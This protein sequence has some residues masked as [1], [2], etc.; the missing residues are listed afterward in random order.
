[1]IIMGVSGTGKS[2][3]AQ[4][5]AKQIDGSYLDADDFHTEAAKLI[6]SEGKSI[7]DT[8]RQAWV[9]DICQYLK[10]QHDN[11]VI[12]LAFSGLRQAHRQQLQSI[13]PEQCSIIYLHGSYDVIATRMSKRNNH[14]VDAGFLDSQFAQ[15]EVPKDD[16]NINWLD[17]DKPLVDL[18]QQALELV[19]SYYE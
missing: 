11:N 19:K 17:I 7:S 6:M 18:K 13:F 5:L 4:H 3:I 9:D 12:C 1:M 8:T 15:L 2:T 10:Q 14:F 16:E